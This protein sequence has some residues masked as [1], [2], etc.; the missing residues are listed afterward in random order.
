M[1]VVELISWLL[2]GGGSLGTVVSF[3]KF[4]QAGE[5]EHWQKKL[6]WRLMIIVCTVLIL[7]GSGMLVSA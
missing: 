7:V 4:K 2:I 1:N 5:W 6:M 3:L